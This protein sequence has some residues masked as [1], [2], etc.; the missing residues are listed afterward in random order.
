MNIYFSYLRFDRRNNKVLCS[1][2]PGWD[3]A[4]AKWEFVCSLTPLFSGLSNT[5]G[6]RDGGGVGGGGKD[7]IQVVNTSQVLQYFA[8]S[9]TDL[10]NL[11]IKNP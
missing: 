8:N 1:C 3:L 7:T 11:M 6:R 2:T 4:V 9:D 5:M 10:S